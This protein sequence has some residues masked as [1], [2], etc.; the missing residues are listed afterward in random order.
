MSATEAQY[1]G[2]ATGSLNG[3]ASSAAKLKQA[4]STNE[5]LAFRQ[6]PH[7]LDVEWQ[8]LGMLLVHNE[9]FELVADFL[10][11]VHFF[12]PLHARIFET[13]ATLI[14]AGKSAT[15]ITVMRIFENVEPIQPDLTVPQYLG[16]IAANGT[17]PKNAT[18][19]G[20]TIYDLAM[21]RALIVLG[22]DMVNTAYDS[23][24][25]CP[26]AEQL[27]QIEARVTALRETDHGRYQI[28]SRPYE[29]VPPEAIPKRPVMY[30]QEIRGFAGATVGRPGVGK[31]KLIVTEALAKVTQRKLSTTWRQINIA[32]GATSVRK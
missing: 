31:T 25:D 32:A 10:L 26:A 11:P 29:Y 12:E 16:R 28:T 24:I 6:A 3:H 30:G 23:T 22:E 7:N 20:R 18:G 15:P 5:Q 1:N 17:T 13:L 4:A 9:A 14:H 27:D 19:H 21:R 8:L 2:H